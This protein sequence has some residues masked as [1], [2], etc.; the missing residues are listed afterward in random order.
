MQHTGLR[1]GGLRNG[2]IYPKVMDSRTC[3]QELYKCVSQIDYAIDDDAIKYIAG[4]FLSQRKLPHTRTALRV[5]MK[6]VMAGN[7]ECLF[8]EDAVNT[9]ELTLEYWGGDYY[10]T[11]FDWNEAFERNPNDYYVYI[12]GGPGEHDEERF[13]QETLDFEKAFEQHRVELGLV[14]P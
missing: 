11:D 7:P 10:P 6:E 5:L 1:Y 14:L 13:Y 8:L 3:I 2:V 4:W 12:Y 9:E